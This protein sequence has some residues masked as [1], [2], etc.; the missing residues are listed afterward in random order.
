[1]LRDQPS[2]VSKV[3]VD[4]HQVDAKDDEMTNQYTLSPRLRKGSVNSTKC[5]QHCR[6]GHGIG[7][8]VRSEGA[9]DGA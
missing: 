6:I 9:G 4:V 3:V 5:L 2:V 7:R 1:M 8:L